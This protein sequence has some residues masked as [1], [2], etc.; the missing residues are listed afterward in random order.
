MK[1]KKKGRWVRIFP[2]LRETE[3][4]KQACVRPLLRVQA[5]QHGGGS[6]EASTRK[7]EAST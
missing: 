5:Q 4:W 7:L 6:V 1:E 2:D 3:T